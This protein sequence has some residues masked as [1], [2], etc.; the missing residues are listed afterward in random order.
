MKTQDITAM[1]WIFTHPNPIIQ[2]CAAVGAGVPEEKA[3]KIVEFWLKHY[4]FTFYTVISEGQVMTMEAKKS[5]NV[6]CMIPSIF[7]ILI[8]LFPYILELAKIEPSRLQVNTIT[9]IFTVGMFIT[10][11]KRKGIYTSNHRF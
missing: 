9:Q 8:L 5:Q 3:D 6:F 7:K 11:A 1:G 4:D 10:Y 2:Y